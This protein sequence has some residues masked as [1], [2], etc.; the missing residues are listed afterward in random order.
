MS[1]LPAVRPWLKPLRQSETNSPRIPR[2]ES[3]SADDTDNLRGE[4]RERRHEAR[5]A[6]LDYSDRSGPPR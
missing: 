1:R 6:A 5:F 3:E 4:E 2:Q